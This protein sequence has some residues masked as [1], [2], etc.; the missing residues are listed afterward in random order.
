MKRSQFDKLL[1]SRWGGHGG[2]TPDWRRLLYAHNFVHKQVHD[3]L[4]GAANNL[5]ARWPRPANLP[6]EDADAMTTLPQASN[7]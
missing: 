4:A 5:P 3:Q 6:K 2:R 7:C 1:S